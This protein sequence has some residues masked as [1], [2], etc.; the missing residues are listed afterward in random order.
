MFT[1]SQTPLL[2]THN[3]SF[4]EAFRARWWLH[5]PLI[6]AF[7]RQRQMDLYEFKAYRVSA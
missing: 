6:P 1:V 5:T 4:K 2:P 7:S 3:P